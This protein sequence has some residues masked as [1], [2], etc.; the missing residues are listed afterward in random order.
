MSN[1]ENIYEIIKYIEYV[2]L[3][4]ICDIGNNDDI[5]AVKVCRK[6]PVCG[7]KTGKYFLFLADNNSISLSSKYKNIPNKLLA[8]MLS[9]IFEDKFIDCYI[10]IDGSFI[11]S[12]DKL[13][14][15]KIPLID[16]EIKIKLLNIIDDI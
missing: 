7:Y 6:Y 13:S 9:Y 2:N 3:E 14:K 15:I 4:D 5:E 11:L 10:I 12:T 16:E 8:Y 1:L